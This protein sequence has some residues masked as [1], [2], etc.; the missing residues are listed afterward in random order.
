MSIGNYNTEQKNNYNQLNVGEI[1]IKFLLDHIEQL[2]QQAL[3]K[4]E[5]QKSAERPPLSIQDL[6]TKFQV[7]KATV[8]NWINRGIIT[9]KKLG[10]GR[11]FDEM[12]VKKALDKYNFTK[13]NRIL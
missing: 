5:E 1:R 13:A 7:S 6:A 4:F 12:E 8:H 2:F 3:E 10:K 9:G 11:F